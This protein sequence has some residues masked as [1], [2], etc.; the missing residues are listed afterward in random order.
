ML[1][2]VSMPRVIDYAETAARLRS[3]GLVSLYHNSGAWGFP[4]DAPVRTLG[5]VTSDDPSI[6]ESARALTR[7]TTI[8]ESA[9]P[10][11]RVIDHLADEAWLMPKS[12]WHYEL[13]FGNRELLQRLLPTIG[14]DPALLRD[15]ND[16]SAIAFEAAEA[17]KQLPGVVA[18]LLPSLR[19]SDF[20]LAWPDAQTLCTIHHHA[21]LWWQ[22]TDPQVMTLFDASA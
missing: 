21:Q 3:R 22:T 11:L 13:H 18:E 2:R 12:H 14:V 5:L 10:L 15:R 4:P 17:K 7:R 16:G 20:M 9:I 6:R 19:G 1:T 8:A